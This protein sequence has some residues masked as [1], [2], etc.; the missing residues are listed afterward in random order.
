MQQIIH[1]LMWLNKQTEL[2]NDK[3]QHAIGNKIFAT[4]DC[5]LAI[6][7]FFWVHIPWS[8]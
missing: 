5:S 4:C 3:Q 6:I 7:V 2:W 1:Y 8:N